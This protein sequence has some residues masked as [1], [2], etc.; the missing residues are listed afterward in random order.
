MQN[1]FN[2]LL[3]TDPDKSYMFCVNKFI[4]ESKKRVEGYLDKVIDVR[5]PEEYLEV[6]QYNELVQKGEKCVS[7]FSFNLKLNVFC[8]N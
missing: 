4:E 3:F 8:K 2:L 5:D 7:P 1:L 6:D